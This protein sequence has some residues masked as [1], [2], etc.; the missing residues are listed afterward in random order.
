[1]KKATQGAG[2]CMVNGM[3]SGDYPPIFTQEIANVHPSY[4]CTSFYTRVALS[5][6]VSPTT[7]L[8]LLHN[9]FNSAKLQHCQMSGMC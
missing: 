7:D 4:F 3:M 8:R 2:L 5:P 6:K 9:L 1:M